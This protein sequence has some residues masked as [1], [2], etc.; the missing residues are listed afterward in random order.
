MRKRSICLLLALLMLLAGCNAAGVFSEE[1]GATWFHGVCERYTGQ[2]SCE[3]TVGDNACISVQCTL[4]CKNGQV[5]VTIADD[6]GTALHRGEDV[7]TDNAF[8]V[9]LTEPGSYTITVD[10]ADYTGGFAFDWET[11]GAAP[12]GS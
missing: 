7:S 1:H 9:Q 8:V 6:E 11:A 10:A 2:R 4:T 5:D 3:L 12:E